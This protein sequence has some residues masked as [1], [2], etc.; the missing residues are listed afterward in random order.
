MHTRIVSLALVVA[1]GGCHG[2]SDSERRATTE[3]EQ[4]ASETTITNAVIDASESV[5]ADALAETRRQQLE[6][7]YR[8]QTALDQ[9]DTR[10]KDAKKRGADHVKLVDA[11]RAVLR[12]DLDALDSSNDD[13]WASLKQKIDRDLREHGG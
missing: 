6:Y 13:D 11:R 4:Q 8:L 10:R 5:E 9:L 1:A 3:A 12:K 2:T 7:R